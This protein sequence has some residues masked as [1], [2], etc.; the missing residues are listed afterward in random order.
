MFSVATV[1]AVFSESREDGKVEAPTSFDV[2][3]RVNYAGS[4]TPR[5]HVNA[6]VV[7]HV[8]VQVV[9][10]AEDLGQ[11]C[12]SHCCEAVADSLDTSLMKRVRRAISLGNVCLLVWK[13][14]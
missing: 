7:V 10:W 3:R 6:N 11:N 12:H 13:V 2:T 4:C 1:F 14:F 5:S 8:R 9:V